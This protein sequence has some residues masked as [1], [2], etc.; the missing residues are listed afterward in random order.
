[1]MQFSFLRPTYC[2]IFCAL[3]LT[4]AKNLLQVVLSASSRRLKLKPPKGLRLT[5][6]ER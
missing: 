5:V 3:K 4:E 2:G 1:M 6:L